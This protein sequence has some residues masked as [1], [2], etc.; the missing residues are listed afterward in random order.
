MLSSF[1]GA[2]Y[3]LSAVPFLGWASTGTKYAVKFVKNVAG[4]TI[5]IGYKFENGLIKWGGN[6]R[7]S[8]NIPNGDSR[9]AHHLIDWAARDNPVVQRAGF[10]TKTNFHM[11]QPSNGIAIDA[12]RNQPNHPQYNQA[13]EDNLF[14]IGET[15]KSRFGKSRVEDLDPVRMSN[16]TAHKILLK[17]VITL[18]DGQTNYQKETS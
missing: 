18:C 2:L 15:L 13:I 17:R 12:W 11:N 5:Q 9:H 1:W 8:L 4:E 3:Y 10:A 14:N 6:L 7:K 16:L